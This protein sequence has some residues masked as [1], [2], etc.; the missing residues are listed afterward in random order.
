MNGER[1][2]ISYVIIIYSNLSPT[3][4]INWSGWSTKHDR[5]DIEIFKIFYMS[6]HPHR[7]N[8]LDR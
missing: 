8:V 3:N 2:I 1:L 5:T 6:M 7:R 4:T